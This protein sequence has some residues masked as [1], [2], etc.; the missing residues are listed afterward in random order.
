MFDAIHDHLLTLLPP[1][2]PRDEWRRI[3]RP[4]WPSDRDLAGYALVE[5][6]RPVA[7][8]GLLFAERW[9]GSRKERFC[10]VTSWIATEPYR[11]ESSLLALQLRSFR[12]HTVTNLTPTA[13]AGR[14]FGRL[15]FES[16]E[17]HRTILWAG[18]ALRPSVLARGLR[19]S[20]DPGDVE[21]VLDDRD[22]ELLETHRGLTHHQVAWDAG[23]Y[24][25]VV[26]TLGRRARAPLIRIHRVSDRA[27]FARWLPRLQLHWAR[28]YGA[29]LAECDSRLVDPLGPPFGVRRARATPRLYRS[30]GVDR[31]EIDNLY[32]EIVL[33]DLP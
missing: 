22:R 15:G 26:F 17:T 16:L 10:N 2:R 13:E 21:A 3:F 29:P 5:G 27:R 31:A 6:D 4:P 12:D 11:G 18:N 32:S 19:V 1:P 30:A 33:L 23:G 24:C 28:E 25:H 9:V 7:F 20:A 14:V 8:M